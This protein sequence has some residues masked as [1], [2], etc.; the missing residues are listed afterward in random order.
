MGNKE[1]IRVVNKGTGTTIG[2][3][4]PEYHSSMTDPPYFYD[5]LDHIPFESDESCIRHNLR[6]WKNEP[7][8]PSD[9]EWFMYHKF[10]AKKQLQYNKPDAPWW[11]E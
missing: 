11:E 2:F 1:V 10:L 7:S 8:D 6:L 4:T 9:Y 5:E 3:V